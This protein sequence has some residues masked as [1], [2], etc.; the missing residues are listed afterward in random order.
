VVALK[1][2]RRVYMWHV[3]PR[4]MPQEAPASVTLSEI[5]G[6]IKDAYQQKEAQIHLSGEGRVLK[7]DAPDSQRSPQNRIYIADLEEGQNVFTV[8]INRGDPSVADAA[9]IDAASGTVRTISPEENE[10][11]GSSAHLVIQKAA[12]SSG[13]FRA[14]FE[15]MPH[16]SSSHAEILLNT[17][18]SRYALADPAYV[19]SKR[20]RKG[21][22]F[23]TEQRPYR[24][25]LT[26]RKVPSEQIKADIERGELA[27]ITL[28]DSNSE[29]TG[30]DAPDV[31]KS[32]Q[33]RLILRPKAADTGRLVSFIN[34]LTPWATGEGFNEIQINVRGLPGNASSQPRFIL[35][36]EDA[37]ET[38]YV[39]TQRLTG[40]S[41]ILEGCYGGI[42]KPIQSKMIA[43]LTDGGKW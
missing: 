16:V 9:Y 38:L 36:Q 4:P 22:Q 24:P 39:R 17:V 20:V 40:F 18:L 6:I 19:Y 41:V 31:I 27:S 13:T 30:P 32:V 8:L 7:D 42:C 3:A 5:L 14:C 25:V 10:S 34:Q 28:I 35:E 2:E 29:F 37:T 33:K 43:L 23:V 11:P 26:V 21:R 1:T 12:D 15:R